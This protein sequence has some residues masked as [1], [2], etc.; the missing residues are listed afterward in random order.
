M[1][2]AGSREQV[3]SHY[4]L[5]G[6]IGQGAMG[7]VVK[8]R[9]RNLNR[10][11]ALKFLA[12]QY[13]DSPEAKERF[14]REARTISALNHPNIGTIYAIEEHAG[15]PFLALEFL[16]GGTLA[17]RTRDRRLALPEL[18]S[19][20]CQLASG[21][22]HAHRHSV[23]HRDVKPAN[24]LFSAENQLKLVDFGLAKWVRATMSAH[25]SGCCGTPAYMAP[26]LMRD[27]QAGECSDIY[28]FGVVL[29]ELAAGRLP[30]IA[31]QPL[32]MFRSVLESSP[33]PLRVLRP[34]LPPAFCAL[35]AQ[36]M[37][38]SRRQRPGSMDQVLTQLKKIDGKAPPAAAEPD[39]ETATQAPARL[40]ER[41]STRRQWILA[42]GALP[43]AVAA[44]V[45]SLPLVRR[46]WTPRGPGGLPMVAV[47]PFE[48]ADTSPALQEFSMG[49]Q[50]RLASL[51]V[52]AEEWQ[53]AISVPPASEVNA[54]NIRTVG[55]A[56]KRLI[57]D[58]A[59]SGSVLRNP[60][61][62]EIVLSLT[63]TATRRQLRSRIVRVPYEELPRQ[64]SILL[65]AALDLLR[66]ALSAAPLMT[67]AAAAPLLQSNPLAYELCLRAE[68]LL[69]RFEGPGSVDAAL[70]LLDQAVELDPVSAS[71]HALR[72]EAL[73]RKYS[74]TREA[75]T[76]DDARAAAVKARSLNPDLREVAMASGLVAQAGG[77]Y[78]DAVEHMQR[79]AEI[80]PTDQEVLRL[81][82]RALAA[83]RKTS[84]A[85][86]VIRR[87]IDASPAYWPA[88]STLGWFLYTQNRTGEAVAQYEA[89]V[90]LAPESPDG[91]Q[92]LGAMYTL[93][94]RE[95]EA[96]EQLEESLRKGPGYL[97]YISLGTLR[98]YMG[99]YDAA[100]DAY[101]QA[102]TLEPKAPE[103][104][105]YLGEALEQLPGQGEHSR[106]AFAQSIELSREQLQANPNNARLWI[107]TAF[108]SA[109]L[110]RPGDAYPA[111]GRAV[112]L[113][114]EDSRILYRAG[115]AEEVLGG[116]ARALRYIAKALE[117]GQ[118]MRSVLREPV[119]VSLRNDPA[120]SAMRNRAP[121]Q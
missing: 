89:V 81:W 29:Y 24:A 97:A 48:S 57:C 101:R 39:S 113:A 55:D 17:D 112:A 64:D 111:L 98:F 93:L 59:F 15:E 95:R 100:A 16:S 79:A 65:Q 67:A 96:V 84:E 38:R 7:R 6:L 8:A 41:K 74:S 12:P 56:R 33:P 66:P 68:G 22:A 4:E 53:N 20:A 105:A 120:F 34:D 69:R 25:Q 106:Q 44:G 47:L 108:A 73:V 80:A 2:A 75:A 82:G 107:E 43:L 63:E 88:Y 121:R 11:V 51:L 91:Y 31:S 83:A 70:A 62:Y 109:K 117:L 78:Q 115:C 32:A 1:W 71:A 99:K 3:V 102:A 35:I 110:K 86:A 5:L 27:E 45:V 10:V 60:E 42:T 54:N 28:S 26:E 50:A 61:G 118:P 23:I 104:W 114:P 116:R 46:I 92:H 40:T 37:N 119:L 18:L 76:L 21:L 103:A 52:Q 19:Y 36:C 85:E 9:D 30:H 94:G 77:R 14:F 58:L 49:L 87:A 72:A 13:L 90:R